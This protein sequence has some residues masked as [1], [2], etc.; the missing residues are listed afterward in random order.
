MGEYGR[1][2]KTRMKVVGCLSWYD[3]SPAWLAAAIGSASGF[4]D[5]IVAVDGAY[6]MFPKGRPYSGSEQTDA[7]TEI[8]AALGLGLT[9]HIPPTVWY[10]NEVEKRGAMFALAEAGTDASDWYY[11]IDA[12]EVVREWPKDLRDRLERTNMDAGEVR[13]MERTDVQATPETSRAARMFHWQT[14]S[15]TPFRKFFRAARGLRPVG[16]HY[17]YIAGDGR[18]LWNVVDANDRVPALMIDDFQ[19][20]HR[21]LMRPQA[22]RAQSREYYDRREAARAETH[23]CAICRAEPGTVGVHLNWRRDRSGAPI[24]DPSAVCVDCE[25]RAEAL[26]LEQIE[27]IGADP[28]TLVAMSGQGAK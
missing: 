17:T 25:E 7:I 5:H 15:T 22:R 12:D 14:D 26:M 23:P 8:C 2:T 16:N 19:I 28:E 21:T 18:A 27:E 3:E 9:L 11:V 10:G 6:F 24:A 4:C 13:M 20:E 1:S